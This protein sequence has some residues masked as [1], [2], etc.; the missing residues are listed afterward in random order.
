MNRLLLSLGALTVG[1]FL[2]CGAAGAQQLGGGVGGRIGSAGGIGGKIPTGIGGLPGRALAA[3]PAGIYPGGGVGSGGRRGAFAVGPPSSGKGVR[4]YGAY[5]PYRVSRWG[6]PSY[7][8]A[9]G[10]GS[11]S[12]PNSRW[13]N[14]DRT[15]SEECRWLPRRVVGSIGGSS[16]H[17]QLCF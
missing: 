11:L 10:A 7:G 13:F 15:T 8:T 12:Y 14:Y 2:I 3:R 9:L 17:V 6:Y 5:E 16:R 1:A 4:Y